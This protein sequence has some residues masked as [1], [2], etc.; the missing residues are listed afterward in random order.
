MTEAKELPTLIDGQIY[1]WRW[2]DEALH[3][4]GLRSWGSY[5]CKSQIAIVRNGRLID[6][7]WSDMSMDH[8]LDPARVLL[9][10]YADEAWPQ[11]SE[12]QLP[13]YAPEDVASMRHPNNSRAPIYLRPGAQRNAERI[14]QEIAY[15]EEKAR[16]EIRSAEHHLTR[17]AEALALLNAGKL[18]E[19]MQ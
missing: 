13:Y 10:L 17:L 16:A 6:T 9:T 8:V 7:Y 4:D 15:R 11:I 5:H 1:Q 12:Y 14:L 19:V 3:H 2:A 18:D